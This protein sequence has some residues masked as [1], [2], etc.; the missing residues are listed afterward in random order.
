MP[1]KCATGYTPSY[2]RLRNKNPSYIR[3]SDSLIWQDL[4]RVGKVRSILAKIYA[5]S[6][7][8]HIKFDTYNRSYQFGKERVEEENKGLSKRRRTGTR[9]CN[10]YR[11]TGYNVMIYLDFGAI[12]SLSDFK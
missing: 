12:N 2:F 4:T 10:I 1:F 8:R 5:Y 7:L 3:R 6:R 11:K 9:L